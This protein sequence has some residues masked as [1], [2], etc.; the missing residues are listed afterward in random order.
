MASRYLRLWGADHTYR[1]LIENMNEGAI[2]LDDDGVILYCNRRFAEMIKFPLEK[3]IGTPISA[4]VA[5]QSKTQFQELMRAVHYDKC[6]MEVYFAAGKGAPVPVYLSTSRQ[7][8]GNATEHTFIV[9]TDLTKINIQ[10]TMEERLILEASV[11]TNAREGIVI[12][13]PNGKIIDVNEAFTRITHYRRNEVLGKNP[14]FLCAS[15]QDKYF[16]VAMWREL[17]KTHHWEGEVWSQR[18]N[19]EEYPVMLNIS[20]L[21]DANGNIRQ[22][23]GLISDITTIK[24]HQNELEHMAHYD[25]L[26]RLPNRVLLAD[27]LQLGMMQ[28]LRRWQHLAVVFLDLDQ[29]K[30]VNDTYGHETGDQLLISL[31]T[32]MKR[33]LREGDT[34]CRLGGDEFVAVLLDLEGDTH[35]ACETTITRLLSAA[36]NPVQIGDHLIQVSASLGITFYPQAEEIG[37]DQLIRQADQAMYQAKQ[38]GK[39]RYH[40]FDADVDRC[41]RGHH[42]SLERIQRALIENEFVLYYQ[43]K[44][45]MRTGEVVGAEALIRWQHPDK[46]LLPPEAFLPVIES[47]PLIVEI[48]E[49]VIDS[50]LSQISIWQ[51]EGLSMHVSVNIS[52]RQLQ[53][54]DFVSRLRSLLALHAEVSPGD[55]ELELLE[56]SALEDLIWVS[57]VIDQCRKLGLLFT[58]DDF[59]TGYSS[60]TYLKRLS[61]SQIKIDQSFVQNMLNDPDDLSILEGI[62]SLANAFHRQAIAEGVETVEHGTLLLQLGCEL[63]QGF[64]IARPM[65]AHELPQWYASWCPDPAWLHLG[66]V[67]SKVLPLILA[68]VEHCSIL[69]TISNELIAEA[70]IQPLNHQHCHFG[71]W[72]DAEDQACLWLNP[73]FQAVKKSHCQF[74]DIAGELFE[75]RSHGLNVEARNRLDAFKGTSDSLLEQL[76][77]LETEIK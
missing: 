16:F 4:R 36:A 5:P 24:E 26:T 11:F 48:G 10:K 56:T 70:E 72:L 15:R 44:V 61:V 52:A 63:A 30:S 60:L 49:W 12:T 23:M 59:G 29:F 37:A 21:H 20:S 17:V 67:S 50:A 42:E 25:A 54:E 6:H 41:V 3:V 43:P 34:L 73:A 76:K 38:A 33:A 7:V 13:A 1:L 45:N 39:N 46:G 51:A 40:V 28:M 2:V 65:P 9:V 58:L 8:S 14:R 75:L 32:V 35:A 27:R 19:G 47:H 55:L 57:H 64:G 31:A 18:K 53:Q 68:R 62:I 66:P 77:R 69:R 71:R 22:F 74:H